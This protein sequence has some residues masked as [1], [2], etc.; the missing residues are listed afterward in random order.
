M[1]CVYVLYGVCMLCL[2]CLSWGWRN[3]HRKDVG[4]EK[5]DS[6]AFFILVVWVLQ[7]LAT[8]FAVLSRFVFHFQFPNNTKSYTQKRVF[9]SRLYMDRQCDDPPLRLVNLELAWIDRHR[10]SSTSSP[11]LFTLERKL[12][13]TLMYSFFFFLK[14][15][16]C[17]FCVWERKVRV[18]NLKLFRRRLSHSSRSDAEISTDRRVCCFS[19]RASSDCHALRF[20]EE[21]PQE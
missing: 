8:W 20:K 6:S 9:I 5:E 2:R 3:A 13:K 18:I 16:L 1:A 15:L 12:N 17:L 4:T 19:S 21:N 14:S 10:S 11:I 7:K